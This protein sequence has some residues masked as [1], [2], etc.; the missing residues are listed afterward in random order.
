MIATIVSIAIC[1]L[2]IELGVPWW[3]ILGLT[4]VGLALTA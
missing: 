2:L 3:T 4:L 1:F